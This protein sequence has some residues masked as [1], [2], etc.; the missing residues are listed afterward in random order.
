M[1]RNHFNPTDPDHCE[2][3]LTDAEEAQ[4][5]FDEWFAR[6]L[7]DQSDNG[8][9]IA[10]AEI[11]RRELSRSMADHANSNERAA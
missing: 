5:W 7:S 1:M 8:Y 4:D 11:E 10:L 6:W 3:E 2:V 9:E